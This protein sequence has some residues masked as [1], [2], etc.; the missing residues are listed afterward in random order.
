MRP[1][2]AIIGAGP[3]G[4]AAALALRSCGHS[5]IVI[6]PQSRREKPTETAVPALASLLRRLGAAEAL[7]ACEPC[8]GI[9]SGWGRPTPVLQPGMMNPY[10]NPWFVHRTRFDAALQAAVRRRGA[11]WLAEQAIAL[12][13]DADGVSISTTGKPIRARWTVIATGSTSSAARLTRQKAM[14]IDSMIAF[15]AKLPTAFKE[16]LLFVE[17]TDASWW[18]LCPADV[19][20]VVACL[21]TDVDV[22]RKLG[23]AQTKNWNELFKA[24]SIS[25][26][27]QDAPAADRIHVAITGLATLPR[28]HGPGWVAVGDAAARLDP[29]GS[30]GTPTALDCGQRAAHAVDAALQGNSTPLIRY[31]AWN[32]HLVEEFTRQRWQQYQFEVRRRANEFWSRRRTLAAAGTDQVGG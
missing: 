25:R 20:G 24:T 15:W 18:Y 8:N 23:P 1:N 7:S 13:T 22:A 10:G 30:A 3:A 16:R 5:V 14:Q 28:T 2:V 32:T 29:L 26:Q 17:P 31:G 19:R 21:I 11:E 6:A 12:T 4:C 27:L 9:I